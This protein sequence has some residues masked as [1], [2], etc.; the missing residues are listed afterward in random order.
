MGMREEASNTME[1]IRGE[2]KESK[3]TNLHIFKKKTKLEGKSWGER[4]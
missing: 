4:F 2:V 1:E 3:K